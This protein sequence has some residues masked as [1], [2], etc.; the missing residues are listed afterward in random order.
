MN[1]YLINLDN[2]KHKQ[3]KTYEEALIDFEKLISQFT[4]SQI[5]IILEEFCEFGHSDS[6]CK[7]YKLVNYDNGNINKYL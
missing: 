2:K 1:I 4:N 5:E 7:L 6:C 3:Y